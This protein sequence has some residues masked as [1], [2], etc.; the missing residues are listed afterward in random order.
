MI[1]LTVGEQLAFDRLV[2][3][4]DTWSRVSEHNV[5]AQIGNA[6]YRPKQIEYIN[7]VTQKE[8]LEKIERAELIIS[9]A[10]MGTIITAL[11][12][13]KRI[14][15]MP[16]DSSL[17]EHRNDHQIKTALKFSELGLVDVAYDEKELIQKLDNFDFFISKEKTNIKLK[18]DVRLVLF[19][20][21]FTK[22]ISMSK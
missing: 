21:N 12:F 20:I 16:R 7:F 22:K 11:D 17:G 6:Q 9:H 19:I 3:A 4:V 13:N 10:G 2:Q 15:V 5:F 14:L 1:F 8:F 18:K